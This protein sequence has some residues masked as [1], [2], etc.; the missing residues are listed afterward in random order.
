LTAYSLLI[1]LHAVAAVLGTGAATAIVVRA[2]GG[3]D[4][5]VVDLRRLILA[6]Q[7]GLGALLVTGGAALRVGDVGSAFV[8][9]WWLRLSLALFVVLG[10]VVGHARR[11]LRAPSPDL[12]ALARDGWIMCV[13]VAAL[14]ILMETK[15]W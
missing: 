6:V 7:I 13:L 3:A 2:R 10:G 12:T 5:A 14:V 15:P 9:M 4:G 8:H 1:A 11:L